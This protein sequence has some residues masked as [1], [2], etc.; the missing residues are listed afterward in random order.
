MIPPAEFHQLPANSFLWQRYDP[1][2]K[3]D[4]FATGLA[5]AAGVFLIDPFA[6]G[7]DALG[8]ALD[9]REI[10][11]IVVTNENHLRTAAAFAEKFAAPIFAH[12]EAR[13]AFGSIPVSEVADGEEISAEIR[14]HHL[15]GAAPGELAVHSSADGGTLVIGD[16]LI[17]FGANGF[18]FL[19]PK[20]CSDAKLMRRSLGKLL[21]LQFERMLFAHGEP[22]LAQ[23]HAR[24]EELLARG[25]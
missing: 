19:P 5:R 21:E 13:P 12:I 6:V 10:N 11:G 4:I 24:L 3:A 20:Y 18:T 2:I 25:S 16:A 17:N 8:E 1:E 9:S 14:V 15:P 22:I 23:A 7:A